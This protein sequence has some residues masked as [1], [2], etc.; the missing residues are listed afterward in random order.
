MI[1][2]G[3]AQNGVKGGLASDLVGLGLDAISC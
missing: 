1:A 2:I 3:L